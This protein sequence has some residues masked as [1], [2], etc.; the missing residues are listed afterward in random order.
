MNLPRMRPLTATGLADIADPCGHCDHRAV[1]VRRPRIDPQLRVDRPTRVDPRSG[2]RRSQRRT[3]QTDQTGLGWTGDYFDEVTDLWGL[4]GVAAHLNGDVPGFLCFAPA[5]LVPTD[6]VPGVRDGGA[7]VF[8]S[9]AAVLTALSVCRAYRHRGLGR[10]LVRA[11]AAQLARRQVGMIEVVGTVGAAGA[12]RIG[13]STSAQLGAG[14]AAALTLLPVGFW[15]AVG[16]RIVRPHPLTPTLRMD[17][18]NTERWLPDFGGAWRRFARLVA[19]P[20][21]PQPAR[22]TDPELTFA[23]RRTPC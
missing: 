2:R 3:G 1:P 4:C 16:F 15:L 9:D 12:R 8:D 21:P 5:E 11:G 18:T 19:Q 23:G 13:R 17:L 10:D 20:G 22:V 7:E 14:R 6:A